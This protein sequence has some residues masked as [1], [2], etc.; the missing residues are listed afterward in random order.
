MDVSNDFDDFGLKSVTD[1][2]IREK[3]NEQ[4]EQREALR[5]EDRRNPPWSDSN[6]NENSQNYD[7]YNNAD[8]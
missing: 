3:I 4:Y 6:S 7:L 2:D 5:K 8:A 1:K